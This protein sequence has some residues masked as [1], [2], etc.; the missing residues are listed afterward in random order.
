MNIADL[1]VSDMAAR[2]ASRK[3][4]WRLIPFLTLCYVQV[5]RVL[6]KFV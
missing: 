5:K 3:A 6:A 2:R 1:N 4:A